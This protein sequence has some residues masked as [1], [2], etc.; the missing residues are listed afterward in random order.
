MQIVH[1]DRLPSTSWIR[2]EHTHTT[3]QNTHIPTQNGNYQV[4]TPKNYTTNVML[5]LFGRSPHTDSTRIIPTLY[6]LFSCEWTKCIRKEVSKTTC[7][8]N[9]SA[10]FGSGDRMLAETRN[11]TDKMAVKIP[12]SNL[13]QKLS[14][15]T[16]I[17]T[18]CPPAPSTRSETPK[19]ACSISCS[20]WSAVGVDVVLPIK[21]I[22]IC[23]FICSLLLK[24]KKIR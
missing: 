22:L 2:W 3:T 8:S 23:S 20:I 5:T 18:L 4:N 17:G 9:E 10:G 15:T 12:N 14:N 21:L 6:K 11:S 7:R 19:C 1:T 16:Q 24:K 13:N